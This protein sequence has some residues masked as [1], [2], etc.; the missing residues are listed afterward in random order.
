MDFRRYQ[1]LCVHIGAAGLGVLFAWQVFQSDYVQTALQ[2]IGPALVIMGV[3]FIWLAMSTTLRSGFSILVYRRSSQTAFGLLF[4]VFVGDS[5]LPTPA[6]AQSTM[7]QAAGSVL[8]VLACLF[9]AVVVAWLFVVIVRF[10]L[11][12][13]KRVYM[14]A[15]GI[16][17]SDDDSTLFDFGSLIVVFAI[18]LGASL[19]GIPNTFGFAGNGQS[20]VVH[21]IDAPAPLV[22]DAMNTATSP[23]IPLP[24]ILRSFPKPTAV[25]V[26]QGVGLGAVRVVKF[27]GREG[28]GHLTLHVTERTKD[29]ARFEVVSDTSPFAAWVKYHALTYRVAPDGGAT[30]LAMT[31]DYERLLAPA[32][33]FTPA[34]KGAAYLAMDVLARDVKHRSESTHE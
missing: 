22:W 9:V 5:V 27:E 24:N 12:V 17:N 13:I 6:E 31:L 20:T 29:M 19:E 34:I 15:R 26:D 25:V 14:W 4:V 10:I 32:W 2:F 8:G 28:V 11:S 23:R 7:L 3:H 16:E 21:V 1:M 30:K 33:F 18:T